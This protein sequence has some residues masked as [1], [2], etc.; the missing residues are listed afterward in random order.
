MKKVLLFA[1]A[2]IVSLSASAQVFNKNVKPI[3]K[4]VKA[5]QISKMLE[6]DE[7]SEFTSSSNC[8]AAKIIRKADAT[9]G[10]YGL[11]L[12]VNEIDN[13]GTL[14]CDSIEIKQVNKTIGETACDVEFKIP[15]GQTFYGHYDP[16]TKTVTC[17]AQSVGTVDYNGTD[18]SLRIY[19]IVE[20]DG[21]YYYDFEEPF[22]FT[23]EDDGTWSFN[24]EALYIDMNENQEMIWTAYYP[25]ALKPVNGVAAY[26]RLNSKGTDYDEILSACNIQDY[27]F[28]VS[29]SGYPALEGTNSMSLAAVVNIDVNDDGTVAL[30]AGQNIWPTS[31][32]LRNQGDEIVKAA[33]PYYLTWGSKEFYDEESG[34]NKYQFDDDL[35]NGKAGGTVADNMIKLNPYPLA[36]KP[37]TNP[38]TGKTNQYGFFTSGS[39]IQL[40][41]GTFGGGVNDINSVSREEMAK[42]AKC[43]N[44]LGQRVKANTKGLVIRDGKKFYNK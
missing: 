4:M 32:L 13:E 38:T 11:Y 8:P 2:A 28:Q 12:M 10:I 34:K 3:S 17:P 18:Y 9:D 21:K 30:P 40:V 25:T 14:G 7:L 26:Y 43:Y 19:P 35:E 27:G 20:Q 36:T 29:V 23:L 42:N 37:F 16:A 6:A 33:G 39:I 1:C 44:I 5:P 22:S 41:N 24:Q 15:Q 31:L